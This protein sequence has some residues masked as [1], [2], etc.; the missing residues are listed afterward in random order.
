MIS[1]I[2]M[3]PLAVL[4]ER[5]GEMTKKAAPEFLWGRSYVSECSFCKKLIDQY[6]GSGCP[7]LRSKMPQ[8]RQLFMFEG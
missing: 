5:S 1:A 2:T 6:D 8:G 7:H 4:E 3:F